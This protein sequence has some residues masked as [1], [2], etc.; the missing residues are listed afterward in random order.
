MTQKRHERRFAISWIDPRSGP[1]RIPRTD[2]LINLPKSLDFVDKYGNDSPHD[3][4][5]ETD[6]ETDCR[7]L[8]LG[9]DV[10]R[11]RG[12]LIQLNDE[13]NTITPEHRSLG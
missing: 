5:S 6:S 9:C 10:F 2:P 13:K 4:Q 12:G 11:S 3:F 7:R 8:C 1:E